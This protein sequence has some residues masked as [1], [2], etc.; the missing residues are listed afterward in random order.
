MEKLL[1]KQKKLL[2]EINCMEGI[3]KGSISTLCGTCN[4]AN[5]IC[6]NKKNNKSYRLTYK[7]RNQKTKTIYVQKQNLKKVKSMIL[8]FEKN[9][10]IIDEIIEININI[11]RADQKLASEKNK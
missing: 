4:R 10:K 8:N 7:D 9:R 11:L 2:A 5:C 1:K 3:L 6:K